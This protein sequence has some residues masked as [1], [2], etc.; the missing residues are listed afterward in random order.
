[1]STEE[2][3]GSLAADQMEPLTEKQREELDKVLF[4]ETHK[5]KVRVLGIVR[6]L[7]PIP[8]KV[9]RAL[10]AAIKPVAHKVEGSFQTAEKVEIDE[11]IL[12]ALKEGSRI[13]TKYYGWEKVTEAIDN[14]E[15][16]TSEL[17]DLVFTQTRLNDTND[18]LLGP[19]RVLERVL[20]L[21][22]IL[23]VKSSS[24]VISMLSP[25]QSA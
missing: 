13:L 2:Q 16:T 11:E 24:I 4:P 5:D 12:E 22:E 8:I 17:Q 7:N 20:Q 3:I 1:M 18:F 10:N 21:T 14:E 9:A 15:V 6:S 19:C 23:R 25:K